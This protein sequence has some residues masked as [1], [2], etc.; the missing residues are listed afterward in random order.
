MDWSNLDRH[1]IRDSFGPPE[2]A[3]TPNGISIGSAVFAE[4]KNVTNTDTQRHR[5]VNRPT[6]LLR[7]QQWSASYAMHAMWPK[8]NIRVKK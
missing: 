1:L 7:L 5:H 2:S 6:T 3:P 8:S 4:L